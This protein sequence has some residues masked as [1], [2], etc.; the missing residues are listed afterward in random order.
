MTA[1]ISG[2]KSRLGAAF[3]YT[4]GAG[5][6]GTFEAI[7]ARITRP[8]GKGPTLMDPAENKTPRPNRYVLM[9][10]ANPLP[11][12]EAEFE[13]GGNQTIQSVLRL[14]GWMA[15]QRFRIAD[16]PGRAPSVKPKYLT[17]WETEGVSAQAVHDTLIEAQKSGAVKKN[18]AA[19]ENTAE[20]VYWEP[21][22]PYITKD[23]FVR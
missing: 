21:I 12:Q 20:M 23:D 22:T 13:K 2:G 8:D 11:G 3:N 19:D 1:A 4:P 14:P 15:A 16:T 10:F 18:A 9:D 7:G 6:N 17:V 5:A